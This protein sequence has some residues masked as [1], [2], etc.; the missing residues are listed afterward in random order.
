[1]LRTELVSTNVLFLSA[2]LCS[3]ADISL[4]LELDDFLLCEFELLCFLF[5]LLQFDLRVGL[6]WRRFALFGSSTTDM[7]F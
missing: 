7:L 2:V 1:M 4:F 3:F 6:I 5:A